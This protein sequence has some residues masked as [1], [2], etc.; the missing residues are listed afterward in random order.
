MQVDIGVDP[1]GNVWAN[2][3]WDDWEAV[4][5]RVE[6]T[7]TT[8]GGGQTVVV[9]YGMAKRVRAPM[10]GPARGTFHSRWGVPTARRHLERAAYLTADNQ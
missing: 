4:L 7:R 8:R 6:E 5:G 3:N 10:I 1:A 9:F 2:N